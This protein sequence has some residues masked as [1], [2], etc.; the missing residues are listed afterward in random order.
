MV[1]VC[2]WLVFLAIG[3]EQAAVWGVA[4]AVL[5]LVP[6]VG[7]LAFAAAALLGAVMQTGDL[8]WALLVAASGLAIRFVSGYLLAPWLTSRASRLSPVAVF[9]AVLAW[10][11][12]WG[13]WGMLLGVP[14]VM[15]V[16]AVC[17]RVDGFKPVGEL[18]GA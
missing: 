3:M 12:L 1:G 17:D 10:G 8:D 13:V 7:S 6:Y 16:K 11:W 9:G 14:I 2:T 18:L 5:N 15:M 4:A